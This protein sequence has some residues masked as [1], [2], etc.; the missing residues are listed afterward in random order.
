MCAVR[1]MLCWRLTA[2]RVLCR[3]IDITRPPPAATGEGG[4]QLQELQVVTAA[5]SKPQALIALLCELRDAAARST[6]LAARAIVFASAV[7]VTRRLTE[8]LRGCCDHLRLSVHEISSRVSSRDQA[9]VL[10]GLAG[11]GDWCAVPHRAAA[12]CAVRLIMLT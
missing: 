7:D 2:G 5:H 4:G 6:G 1:G 12:V 3:Y 8:L 11:S 10:Q 9:A